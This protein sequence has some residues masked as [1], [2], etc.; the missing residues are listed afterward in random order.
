MA[1]NADEDLNFSIEP[2]DPA[3][4]DRTAFSCGTAQIDNFLKRTAKKQ[5]KS[6]FTRLWVAVLPGQQNVVGYYAINNHGIEGDDLPQEI[7]K[8]APNH[9]YIPAAYISTFGV[10]SEL[11]GRG[12]G[13]VLLVDALK[14]IAALSEQIG[15][16]VV[17]LDVLEDGDAEAVKKRL[18]FYKEFNFIPFPSQP[19][20]MFLP[21]KTVCDL[22]NE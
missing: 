21:I 22:I 5:Q 9:G 18:H 10:T 13:R 14:R 3:T 19:L 11:Q 20:R 15:V 1:A 2:F 7:T 12:L 4:H 6:K 17:I 16:T 8:N